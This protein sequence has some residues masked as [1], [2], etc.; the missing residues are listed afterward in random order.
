MD[1]ATPTGDAAVA[2][3]SIRRIVR[4]LRVSSRALEKELGL[5]GAQLF[6]LQHVAAVPAQS[7]SDLAKS[8]LT[9]QSSVSVVVSRLIEK[10]LVMRAPSKTD[11]RR[12]EISLSAKGRTL[13]QRAPRPA[14][15]RLIEGL[16]SLD[17][18]ELSRLARSLER[19]VVSMGAESEAPEMFFEDES[20]RPTRAR[21]ASVRVRKGRLATR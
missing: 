15:T 3:D 16:L 21:G 2:L 17:R 14:Q 20:R 5:S 7:I 6:V 8:T 11:A 12:V 4:T 1:L 18:T 19:L 13:L 9:D 10:K